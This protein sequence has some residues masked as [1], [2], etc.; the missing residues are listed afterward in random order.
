[1]NVYCV[2]VFLDAISVVNPIKSVVL[3]KRQQEII[4][5]EKVLH[6]LC[7]LPHFREVREIFPIH[8]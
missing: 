4:I 2:D 6:L 3:D 1:M 7:V 8:S 5:S